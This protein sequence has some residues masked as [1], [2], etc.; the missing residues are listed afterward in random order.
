MIT[1][2]VHNVAAVKVCAPKDISSGYYTDILFQ[3]KSGEIVTFT[4]FTEYPIL[5]PVTWGEWSE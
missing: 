5:T 2:N 3:L 4:A 1:T